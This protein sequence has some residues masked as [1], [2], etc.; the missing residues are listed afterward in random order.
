MK[1]LIVVMWM[2][3]A[4]AMITIIECS[5][6]VVRHSVSLLYLSSHYERQKMARITAKTDGIS[7]MHASILEELDASILEDVDASHACIG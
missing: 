2:M 6:I 7:P 5:S 4:T 1:M 3:M